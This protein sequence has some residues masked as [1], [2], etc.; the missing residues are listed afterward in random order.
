MRARLPSLRNRTS[1]ANVSAE[2]VVAMNGPPEESAAG[3]EL[4]AQGEVSG[5]PK[6]GGELLAAEKRSKRR[7]LKTGGR[8]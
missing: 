7:R 8:K 3:K 6:S 5:S 1:V 4:I 2:M